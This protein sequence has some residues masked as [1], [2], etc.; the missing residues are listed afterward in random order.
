MKVFK[1][2]LI[3]LFVLSASAVT[4]TAQHSQG[5][6]H[7][8]GHEHDMEQ[9]K[10][11]DSEAIN[12]SESLHQIPTTWVNQNSESVQI[13]DF[14]GQPLIVV[15]FYGK[16]TETCPM[17]IQRTWKLYSSLSEETQENINV[18]AVS[19]D[20]KNDTPQALKEYAEYEQLDLPDWHFVT[21]D[22]MDIR[23]LASLLGVQY[24]ERSDGHFDHSNLITVLDKHGNISHRIEGIIGN[25]ADDITLIESLT[26]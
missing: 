16:C 11:L 9:M 14:A 18:L 13:K 4:A 21:A 22:Q 17:L 24:R 19:F 6:G 1:A 25:L 10:E 20:Y 2:T 5:D 7:D 3:T 12:H 15:M 8:H 23:Q 26:R